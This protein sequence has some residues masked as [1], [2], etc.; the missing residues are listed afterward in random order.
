[1]PSATGG[2]TG[3]WSFD[4]SVLLQEAAALGPMNR[5][6]KVVAFVQFCLMVAWIVR[7]LALEPYIGTCNDGISQNSFDC[8]NGQ[9]VSVL[10]GYDCGFACMAAASLYLIPSILHPGQSI[11]TWEVVN[12]KFPWDLL[13]VFGGG[14][15]LAEGFKRSELSLVIADALHKL[16]LLPLV[17]MVWFICTVVSYLTE[18][19]TALALG[20]I[21]LPIMAA[22]GRGTG[23]HPLLLM[24]SSS[25]SC[26]LAFM[27][28]IATPPNLL[29][30]ASGYIRF[31][32][33][34]KPGAIMNATGAFVVTFWLFFTAGAVFSTGAFRWDAP[35]W[36]GN[37][38]L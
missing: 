25:I 8:P 32:T 24:L 30:Y 15:A 3:G 37:H 17:V 34:S 19:T 28:P 4:K 7:P 1:M 18:V 16:S 27:L 2:S 9:W 29:V 6:E 11:I 23:V 13:F 5:D 14:F 10:A 33:M 22:V 21:F 26:S 36:L 31:W 35:D 20:T 38:T 12:K